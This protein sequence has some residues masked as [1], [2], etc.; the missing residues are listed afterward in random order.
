M[1]FHF[2]LPHFFAAKVRK[3]IEHLYASTAIGNLAQAMITLF[4]PIFLFTVIGLSVSEVLLFMAVVYAFYIVLIPLGAKI[5]SKFGYAH[6]V[7]FSIP[8]QILFWF[9]LL[10]AEHNIWFLYLAPILY[11]IQKSLFWPA[12]HATLARFANGTQVAREFSMMYA[13]MNL[14]QILGPLI[15]GFLSM[16]LGVSSIFVIGSIIYLCSAVPL[17]MTQEIFVPHLYHYR[18]TWNLIKSYP[19]RFI[20]YLGFGEEL[21]VLT[22]W[23]IFIFLLI[24]NYQDTGLIVTVATLVATGLALLIG[25]YSDGHSKRKVLRIGNF[26]YLLSWLARIPVINGFG[27]L[28]TDSLSRTS[29]SLVFI[30]MVSVT[31]E[32]AESTHILPYIVGFEQMLSVGKFLAAVIGMIV[33]AL[34]GSFIALFILA[35]IFS[36]F[37]F[38]V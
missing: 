12:W 17:L 19:A 37:C 16:F 13:I 33:F 36:L 38:L 2:H 7:F 10:G 34:T 22:V 11:A 5:A 27:V 3:E 15:G 32:R 20:G 6:S 25:I 28:I 24:K 18:D 26:F 29:K 4:E 30:P 23:P 21:I 1:L 35:A 8:F 31:Y 14:M 9:S